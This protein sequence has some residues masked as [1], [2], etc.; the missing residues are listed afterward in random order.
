[1]SVEVDGCMSLPNTHDVQVGNTATVSGEVRTESG[2]K[3]PGVSVSATGFSSQNVITATD[4]LYELF[5]E[6]NE[7]Y[8][9]TPSKNND[10]VTSNGVTTLDLILM[11]RHI[12]NVD[13]LDSPYKLLAADVDMSDAITTLDIVLAQ[14]LILQNTTSYPNGRLWSFINADH[15]FADPT[16]PFPYVETRT[17]ANV[18]DAT[19]QDFIGMKLG[20]V[21]NSWNS[22]IAKNVVEPIVR[23]DNVEGEMNSV[24]SVP[25]Y[26]DYDEALAGFQ[27]TF[28][29]DP[30]AMEFLSVKGGIMNPKLGQVTENGK[31][32]VSW[33]AK[34]IDGVMVDGKVAFELVFRLKNEPNAKTW[35]KANSSI[36]SAEVYSTDLSTRYVK[37]TGGEI[38]LEGQNIVSMDVRPNPFTDQLELTF[39]LTDDQDVSVTMINS[40]GA[41]VATK[42][43]HFYAGTQQ[44]ML[45]D[46]LF[47]TGNVS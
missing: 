44:L 34:N 32:P 9:V 28:D 27:M 5:L 19:N 24:V 31:V 22:L 16:N 2:S 3:V 17:Y 6:N 8:T 36:I 7:S 40:L 29:W 35:V 39:E 11:Q 23:I 46:W 25:V 26:F 43:G 1:M 18:A 37:S 20:D 47:E 15:V 21:N 33:Y 14:S 13:P 12:L 10:V 4:G 41:Q 45:N 38:M 42:K 30:S